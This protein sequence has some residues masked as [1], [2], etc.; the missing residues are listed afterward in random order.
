MG[1]EKPTGAEENATPSL[2]PLKS[3]QDFSGQMPPTVHLKM[4]A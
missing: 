1:E 4:K 3:H 2:S